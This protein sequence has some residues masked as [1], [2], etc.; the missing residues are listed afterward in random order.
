MLSSVLHISRAIA[1]NIEIMRAFVRL[2]RMT[3]SVKEL[4]AK[5]EALEQTYDGQFVLVFD[6]IK[7]LM[8]TPVE[9]P[10]TIG[11]LGTPKRTP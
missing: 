6:A 9:E 1:V 4:A 10:G 2:R 7:E 5:V 11:F 3:L 8:T